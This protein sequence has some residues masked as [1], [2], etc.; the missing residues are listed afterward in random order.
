[1]IKVKRIF[2]SE[3][4]TCCDACANDFERGYD[5][6]ISAKE[7]ETHNIKLCGRCYGI[8]KKKIKEV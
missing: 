7:F 8:L 1:M 5:I 4:L 3:G 2:D 6:R